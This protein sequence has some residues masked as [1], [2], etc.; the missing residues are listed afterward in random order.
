MEH[1]I[2][3]VLIINPRPYELYVMTAHG[4][5][6]GMLAFFF[7]FC[8]VL[9]GE[10]F[11]KMIV[12][13][14]WLF[15]TVGV[16]LFALRINQILTYDFLL[17]IESNCWVLSVLAFGNLYLNRPSKV[18]TYLSEAAYPIYI[19]HM[20]FLYLGSS[21]IFKM[22]IAV[23]LQYAFTVIFTLAGCFVTYEVIR[24]VKFLRPLFGLKIISTKQIIF[25]EA[26][27]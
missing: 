11:L 27:V 14:R 9:S 4:F 7:G 26:K 1:F 19:L 20:I 12:K 18:L 5:F 3:E 2:A 23:E 16:S 21:F 22:N 24:R 25:V 13:W 10:G 15:L 6:L 17:P 8:F